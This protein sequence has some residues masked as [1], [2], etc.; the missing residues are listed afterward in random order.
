MNEAGTR[1]TDDAT[2]RELA[3]LRHRIEVLEA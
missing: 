1:W 2:T 3:R